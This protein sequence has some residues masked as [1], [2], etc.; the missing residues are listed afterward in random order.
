MDWSR[1]RGSEWTAAI[2]GV[3]VL[4][5]LLFLNWYNVAAFSVD[6]P[7][8]H[9]SASGDLGAWDSEGFLGILAN[10]VILAAGLA[11]VGLAFLTAGSRTVALPVATS[12]LTTWLG[13]GAVVMVVGRMLFQPGPNGLVDLEFGIFVALIG[14]LIIA[15]G[16]W[17]SM[18]EE[19][20]ARP[21]RRA[22]GPSGPVTEE[23]PTSPRPEGE[24]PPDEPPAPRNRN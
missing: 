7:F 9:F 5:A 21:S 6:L 1:L 8:G 13:I 3:V 20:V 22:P 17:Q 2:G 19:T 4:I 11:A 10:L 18:Q 24:P 16:G 12:A 23:P 14:A 15:Y